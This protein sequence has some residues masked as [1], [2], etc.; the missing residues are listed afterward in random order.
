E[1]E[2][3][4]LRGNFVEVLHDRALGSQDR[5][6]V[7]HDLLLLD[8]EDHAMEAVGPIAEM[9][10]RDARTAKRIPLQESRVITEALARREARGGGERRAAVVE[11]LPRIGARIERVEAITGPRQVVAALEELQ[12]QLR[13]VAGRHAGGAEEVGE[14]GEGRLAEDDGAGAAQLLGD[15]RIP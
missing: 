4:L 9:R 13:A 15:E 14:L 10:D 7:V 12:A 3:L 8:A 11:R 1:V 5:N 2:Q 6:G